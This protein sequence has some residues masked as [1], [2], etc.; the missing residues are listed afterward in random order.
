MCWLSVRRKFPK[1][2]RGIKYVIGGVLLLG[3]FVFF[4]KHTA[5][6]FQPKAIRLLQGGSNFGG[7]F[8]QGGYYNLAGNKSQQ[9]LQNNATRLMGY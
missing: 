4:F 5:S 1:K 8:N 9:N 2:L 3:V 7:V 6:A